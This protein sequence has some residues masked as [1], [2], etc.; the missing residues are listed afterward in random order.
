MAL[1]AEFGAKS[2]PQLWLETAHFCHSNDALLTES[3]LNS[4]EIRILPYS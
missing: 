3:K 2:T 1:V 4:H